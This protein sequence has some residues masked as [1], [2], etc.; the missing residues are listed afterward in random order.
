M[1][2]RIIAEALPRS[3]TPVILSRIHFLEREF[4]FVS[5]KHSAKSSPWTLTKDHICKRV[6]FSIQRFAF[7]QTRR[8]IACC[9]AY[10]FVILSRPVGR[11]CEDIF[12][13][14]RNFSSRVYL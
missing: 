6:S 14:Y 12:K 5:R 9:L 10:L 1:L 11:S 7:R 2:K 3:L 4:S 13:N 8:R